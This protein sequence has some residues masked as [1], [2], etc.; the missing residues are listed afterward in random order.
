M[1]LCCWLF[2]L[3]RLTTSCFSTWAWSTDLARQMAD[4]LHGKLGVQARHSN[5]AVTVEIEAYISCN[6]A[7]SDKTETSLQLTR[8]WR[9]MKLLRKR[10]HFLRLLQGKTIG[11]IHLLNLTL[12]WWESTVAPEDFHSLF[13]FSF[14]WNQII[15]IGVQAYRHYNGRCHSSTPQCLSKIEWHS[16]SSR[17]ESWWKP[18]WNSSASIVLQEDGSIWRWCTWQRMVPKECL[19]QRYTFPPRISWEQGIITCNSH[20]SW[21]EQKQIR[22]HWATFIASKHW[23][24]S[25]VSCFQQA[26]PHYGV[27]ST[28]IAESEHD[29]GRI[30]WQSNAYSQV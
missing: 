9:V 3:S 21:H 29:W 18:H 30:R 19:E 6:R 8:E 10:S 4:I 17:E 11:T 25:Y 24:P 20:S 7:S 22:T 27:A 13:T 28:V 15:S 14:L 12:C 26:R 16:K 2:P 1:L 23:H 5:I